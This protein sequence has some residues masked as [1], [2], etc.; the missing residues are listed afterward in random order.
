MDTTKPLQGKALSGKNVRI[1][2]DQYL[3]YHFTVKDLV[4][5]TPDG[6]PLDGFNEIGYVFEYL[7]QAQQ[8]CRWKVDRSPKIRCFVYDHRWKIIDQFTNAQYMEQL[9]R[10]SSPQRQFVKGMAFLMLGSALI[11]LDAR[12]RWML[13]IGVLVGARFVV[14]GFVHI[15]LSILNWRQ[16]ST[17]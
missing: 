9:K 11:W 6:N 8:Y 7:P 13:I 17:E 14:G 12:H 15:T 2:P 5:C 4:R 10:S 3:V 1:P 16:D